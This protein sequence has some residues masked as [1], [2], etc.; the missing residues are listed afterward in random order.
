MAH[1][2]KPHVL[3]GHHSALALQNCDSNIRVKASTTT[4]EFAQNAFYEYWRTEGASSLD[5]YSPAA[6]RGFPTSCASPAGVVTCTTDD[7][8]VVKFARSA[9]TR[10]S[11]DEARSYAAHANLGPTPTAIAATSTPSPRRAQIC[12]PGLTIPAVTIPATTIPAVT[13]PAVDLGGQHYPAQHYSAH[14]YRAQ[15]YPAQHYKR[16]CFDAPADFAPA[17]TTLLDQNAYRSLDPEYSAGLSRRYWSTVGG[18]VDYPNPSA[19]GFG[20]LNGAGFPKNQYVRPY[21]RNDGTYVSGYWRNSPSDGLPT[22][23]VIS[24]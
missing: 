19:S 2:R 13:I 1:P 10:Y 5:V 17:R 11:D 12:Y 24:C 3:S 20:E 8:G 21:V 23:S 14:H 7:G 18:S 16:Q 4:C 6:D 15:R 22:C 9:V